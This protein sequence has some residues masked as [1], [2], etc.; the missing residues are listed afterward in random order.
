[1][2]DVQ[3]STARL[4]YHG[5]VNC[6]DGF[7]RAEVD[8]ERRRWLAVLLVAF[9]LSRMVFYALGVRFNAEG[10]IW[11]WQILDPELLR[12]NLSGSV[13]WLHAQPPLFNLGLGLALAIAGEGAVVFLNGLFLAMGFLLA[14]VAYGVLLEVGWPARAAV[15]AVVVAML[16]P[17]WLMYESW[18]FY[19]FPSAILLA[20][21]TLA[22]LRYGRGHSVVWLVIFVWSSCLVAL[23]RS[24]FHLTWLLMALAIV[25]IFRARP[26]RRWIVFVLLP[27]ALVGGLY[28]KNLMIFG[29][30]GSSSWL[31]M[32]AAK[33]TVARLDPR[34]RDLLV[35]QG[36]LSPYSLEPPF[37]PLE[38]YENAAGTRFDDPL[39]P[40]LGRRRKS[41][42]QPNFNHL[43]FISI[44]GSLR[45]DAVTVVRTWPDVYAGAVSVAWRRFFSP[46]VAYPP[47]ADNLL[48]IA[49][50][51]HLSQATLGQPAFAWTIYV[52][53][54]VVAAL[55]CWMA[56][57]AG[58]KGLEAAAAYVLLNLMW[59]AFVGNLLEVGE[60]HRFRFVVT[61]LVWFSIAAALAPLLARRRARRAFY[62]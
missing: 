12:S 14:L 34:E 4:A 36:E 3:R 22:L 61:P 56:R 39:E 2:F 8:R 16:T 27:I 57:T 42:G 52:A 50:L 20:L 29:F 9:A 33:M 40:V 26:R 44:S 23:M 1:M 15:M 48:A 25:L 17:G 35:R 28:L 21:S 38:L 62:I 31:G 60:N 47:F 45:G 6:D 30:F 53:A 59:V 5:H 13:L 46:V 18:L 41:N 55:G 24:L 58:N 43:A 19:D 32:S 54:L 11:Y 37:S 51:F 49:P 10:L 7:D